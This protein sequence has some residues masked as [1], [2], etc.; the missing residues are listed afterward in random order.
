MLYPNTLY[1]LKLQ[2]K[3]WYVGTTVCTGEYRVQQHR[4]GH[5]SIWTRKHPMIRCA[6]QFPVANNEAQRQ[7][8]AVY[9]WLARRYGAHN[10]R[11]GDVV[12]GCDIVPDYLLP[13]E[14][15]GTRIVDW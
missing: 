10:V 14:F 15:G 7:E 1:V 4:N 11:G 9:M 2:H 5:G 12:C 8:N 13:E 3:K 6:H